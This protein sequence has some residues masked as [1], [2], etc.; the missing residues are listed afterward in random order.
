M[1]LE[2]AK[3]AVKK[4]VNSGAKGSEYAKSYYDVLPQSESEYGEHGLDTQWLYILCNLSQW[5]GEEAREAKKV[6]K[7]RYH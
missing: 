4:W 5:K 7:A 1:T 3:Q 2:Q 6:L